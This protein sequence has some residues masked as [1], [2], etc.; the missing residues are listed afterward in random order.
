MGQGGCF[1]PSLTHIHTKQIELPQRICGGSDSGDGMRGPAGG[2]HACTG[3]KK[4]CNRQSISY[5]PLS[6]SSSCADKKPGKAPCRNVTHFPPSWPGGW[7]WLHA[8]L[9]KS[10]RCRQGWL[11]TDQ[12]CSRGLAAIWGH[13]GSRCRQRCCRSHGAVGQ[14]RVR[15]NP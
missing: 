7:G 15:G 2:S 6:C 13:H 11:L 14:G 4:F 1:S 9:G 3:R 10:P 5:L 8:S 12:P